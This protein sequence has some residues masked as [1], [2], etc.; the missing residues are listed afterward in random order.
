MDVGRLISMPARD[1]TSHGATLIEA[2]LTFSLLLDGSEGP[3]V[4]SGTLE[5]GLAATRPVAGLTRE[6]VDTVDGF[7]TGCSVSESDSSG[8]GFLLFLEPI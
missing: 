7:R 5:M 3:F 8:D 6:I 1:A 2:K 4:G